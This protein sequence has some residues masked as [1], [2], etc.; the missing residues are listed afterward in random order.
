MFLSGGKAAPVSKA[1]VGIDPGLSGGLAIIRADGGVELCATPVYQNA[2]GRS[3]YIEAELWHLVGSRL[4]ANCEVLIE[5]QWARPG[6]GFS[7]GKLMYGYGLWVMALIAAR[8]P[9]GS[10][11]PAAWK[12]AQGLPAKSDKAASVQ[13]ALSRYPLVTADLKRDTPY[14]GKKLEL[15]F[16]DGKAEAL[17][18]ADHL[19]NTR[20][21]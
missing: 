16:H 19:K 18:I 8:R 11:T 2:K 20:G 14:R 12:K 10:V 7:S 21:N 15:I 4:P 3:E 17:L 13:L 5:R 9:W 1:K 6:Q